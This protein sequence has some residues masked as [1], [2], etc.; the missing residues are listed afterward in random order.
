MTVRSE[1]VSV[2]NDAIAGSAF[3]VPADFKKSA[4]ESK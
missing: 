2:S 4:L 3:E 1:L